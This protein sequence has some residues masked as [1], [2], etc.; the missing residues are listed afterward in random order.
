MTKVKETFWTTT[1]VSLSTELKRELEQMAIKKQVPISRLVSFALENE[2]A[3]RNPFN[4]PVELEEAPDVDDIFYLKEGRQILN[5]LMKIPKGIGLVSLVLVRRDIGLP[6]KE[7]LLKA[8]AELIKK[9]LAELYTSTRFSLHGYP[10]GTVMV[11]YK[12]GDGTEQRKTE[13]LSKLEGVSL[14]GTHVITDGKI[15]RGEE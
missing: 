10:P 14:K 7:I 1:A 4:Y 9:G 15:D 2:F 11:R 3:A 5:F 6:D 12:N 8:L 13:R